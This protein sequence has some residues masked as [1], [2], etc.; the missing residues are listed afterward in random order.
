MTWI[1]LSLSLSVSSFVSSEREKKR[2]KLVEP[3]NNQ[4]TNRLLGN[5]YSG[6]GGRGQIKE[7]EENT[8]V[9]NYQWDLY[10]F[11][12]FFI[13]SSAMDSNHSPVPVL[14]E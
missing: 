8:L 10:I 5:A 12:L 3:N 1:T 11:F 9:E 13:I 6:G 2:G 14:V 4:P 7:E